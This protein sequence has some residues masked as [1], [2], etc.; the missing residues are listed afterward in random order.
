MTARASMY[1]VC[2][3]CDS[4]MKDWWQYAWWENSRGEPQEVTFLHPDCCKAFV[5]MRR[6]QEWIVKGSPARRIPV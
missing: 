3:F 6:D 4:P 2:E 5:T 1:L